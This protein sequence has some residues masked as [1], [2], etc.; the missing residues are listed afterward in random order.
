MY[1]QSNKDDLFSIMELKDELLNSLEEK[2]ALS[3]TEL[4]WVASYFDPSFKN[5]SLIDY[6]EYL[7]K[8]KKAVRKSIHI[9]ATDLFD[10]SNSTLLKI[11]HHRLIRHHRSDSTK[12]LL[13]TVVRQKPASSSPA[14]FP[15]KHA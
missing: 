7:D 12:M 6:L 5:C 2:H 14:V 8:K 10:K 11:L 1:V 15:A 13:L 4:H 3:I 9:L